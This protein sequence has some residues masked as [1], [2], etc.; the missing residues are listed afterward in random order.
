MKQNL[1]Q[2]LYQL[3]DTNK[4]FYSKNNELNISKR[5]DKKAKYWDKQLLDKETHLNQNDEYSN[6]LEITKKIVLKFSKKNSSF[7]D[8]GCGTGLVSEVLSHYFIKG[9]GIDISECMIMEAKKKNIKNINF[10]KKS[11]F[12][13]NKDK[14]GYFDCIV[15]RGILISHYGIN[16]LA[17]IFNIMFSIT[18]NNGFVVIDFLNQNAQILDSHTPLNKEYYLQ[19][20]I[21]QYALNCL[22]SKVE[23]YGN[24]NDRVLIAILYK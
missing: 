21:E 16:Y 9:V 19:N 2:I 14:D 13:L 3:E 10:Y 1:N 11:F 12:N 24:N 8:L 7:L 6:F 4:E 23:I 15:S 20:T 5:W 17:E 18:K 22:F